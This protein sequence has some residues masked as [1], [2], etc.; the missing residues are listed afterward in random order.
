MTP[1]VIRLLVV[2]AIVITVCAAVITLTAAEK[3]SGGK[4][5]TATAETRSAGVGAKV[6][7][8]IPYSYIP[9]T[10]KKGGGE[11]KRGKTIKLG[12]KKRF[13]GILPMNGSGNK[14]KYY[15]QTAGKKVTNK[16]KNPSYKPA[17]RKYT[18]YKDAYNETQIEYTR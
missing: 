3:R 14:A 7:S 9:A 6:K 18:T 17:E 16:F 12:G 2:S 4:N 5:K 10:F 15:M 13:S 8:Y 11:R 1:P